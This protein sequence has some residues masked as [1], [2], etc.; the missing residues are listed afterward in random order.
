MRQA[1]GAIILYN[2]KILLLLRDNDEN[3]SD[4]NLWGLIGGNLDE[5]ENFEE[6]LA[7]EIQEEAQFT[8]DDKVELGSIIIQ[9]FEQIN[10]YVVNITE[11]DYKKIQLGDEGQELGWF[12]YDELKNLKLDKGMQWYVSNFPLG[13]EKLFNEN[14]VDKRLLGFDNKG[15]KIRITI[16][17]LI[18]NKEMKVNSEFKINKQ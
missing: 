15:H 4:P 14:K 2:N 10:L 11:N 7:R 13:L 9:D 17:E 8:I 6:A 1:V 18:N 3:I 16:D 5:S 12:N